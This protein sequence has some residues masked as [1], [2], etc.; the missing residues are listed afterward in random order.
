MRGRY[1]LG[2]EAVDQAAGSARAKER[3]KGILETLV[4]DGRV[5]ETCAQLHISAPRF[6]QLR[7]KVLEAALASLEP[8]RAGRRPHVTTAAELEIERLKR[9]VAELEVEVRAAQTRAEIALILP[10]VQD[11]APDAEKKT[12]PP[13]PSR[14]GRRSGRRTS[15]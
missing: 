7:Q 14:P 4:G 3:L 9:R 11:A 15:T 12:P 8:R 5:G 2:L 10:G 6:Q 13:R 1:P